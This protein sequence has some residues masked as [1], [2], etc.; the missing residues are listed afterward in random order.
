VPDFEAVA[1]FG[2]QAPA[3]V[4]RPIIDKLAQTVTGI[5]AEPGVV[6]RLREIG[7]SPKPLGP[8]EFD[9]YIAAENDKWRDVVKAAGAK[10]D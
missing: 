10:L 2:F 7:S 4:P 1:W 5:V 3:K 8:A 9:R 6:E